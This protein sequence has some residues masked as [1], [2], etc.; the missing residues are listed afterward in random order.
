MALT[1]SRRLPSL[2]SVIRP[3]SGHLHVRRRQ[4]RVQASRALPSACWTTI[5]MLCRDQWSAVGSLCVTSSDWIA[6]GS[7][8]VALAALALTAYLARLNL[9]HQRDEAHRGRVWERKVDI[10]LEFLEWLESEA[11]VGNPRAA[12]VTPLTA[13]LGHLVPYTFAWPPSRRTASW[14]SKRQRAWLLAGVTKLWR[15]STKAK[16]HELTWALLHL[17]PAVTWSTCARSCVTR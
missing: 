8:S 11:A 5:V 16:R 9:R 17:K 1:G 14:T 4:N 13:L 10:L 3:K 7:T 2:R 6:L 15:S 12:A